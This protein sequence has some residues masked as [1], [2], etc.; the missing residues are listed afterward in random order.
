MILKVNMNIVSKLLSLCIAMFFGL[1]IANAQTVP[2]KGL[3]YKVSGKG[4]KQ[5][6]YLFGTYHLLK[7]GYLKT[8][9]K[10]I[11]CFNQCSGV[12]V[13]VDMRASDP[14]KMAVAMM[15]SAGESKTIKN[16]LTEAEQKIL[17]DKLSVN[18]MMMGLNIDMLTMFKPSALATLLALE[19]PNDVDSIIESYPGQGMDQ[20]FVVVADSMKKSI[21]GLETI[22]EQTGILFDQPIDEQFAYLKKTLA[23][24]DSLDNDSR[25]LTKAYL[26]GDMTAMYKMAYKYPLFKKD[27]DKLLKDRNDKWLKKLPK[28]FKQPQFIAVGALHL[29]GEEGL[30]YQ[31]QKM[32]YTVEPVN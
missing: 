4:L 29:A 26:T 31:L 5:P 21:L 10:V 9:P 24:A 17:I 15:M 25:I 16:Q 2:T 3:L 14:N 6:S 18:P 7:D 20:Y 28:L 13:E 19:M 11:E 32:G 8:Q 23:I 12:V 1:F 22:E 27:M 30:V